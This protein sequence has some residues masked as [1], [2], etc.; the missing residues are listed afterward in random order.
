M[1]SLLHDLN[2][3]NYKPP[4]S[5]EKS[6]YIVKP[7]NG[8]QGRG[9]Y[10]FQS[11]N[12]YTR[13]N[14]GPTEVDGRHSHILSNTC[15]NASV[16]SF[17]A[18]LRNQNLNY[19]Q[20]ALDVVQR[21]EISPTLLFGY[22]TDLRV[23]AVIE[24]LVP[25]KIHIY[26][27]G[28]VRL[29]SR[30]YHT[31]DRSNLCQHT[32][33]LTNYAI[34]KL[35]HPLE[36]AAPV[37]RQTAGNAV[38]T[39]N[40]SQSVTACNSD[41]SKWHCKYSLSD[42][43]RPKAPWSH[44]DW[45]ALWSRV[46]DI[47]RHTIFTL[48]PELKVSYWAEYG[49]PLGI[50][51]TAKSH[52]LISENASTFKGP[53]CFQI[54][55]FDFLLVEPG[56]HPVLL[57]VN[58]NPSLRTDSVQHL[59]RRVSPQSPDA[60][61]EIV[62]L[63]RDLAAKCFTHGLVPFGPL[64]EVATVLSSVMGD[65]YAHFERS[66]VDEKVKGGLIRSTIQLIS[67][68]IVARYT[69]PLEP[70]ATSM[71]HTP[72]LY[73]DGYGIQ[74][75]ML[76]SSKSK[77]S[78]TPSS[79]TVKGLQHSAFSRSMLPTGVARSSGNPGS[80]VTNSICRMNRFSA[81]EKSAVE[82]EQG[83][84]ACSPSDQ[85]NLLETSNL[86]SQ[87]E[88]CTDTTESAPLDCIYFEGERTSH[89]TH[90]Y[91]DS[92]NMECQRLLSRL[93]ELKGSTGSL[94]KHTSFLDALNLDAFD[95]APR[96]FDLLADMFLS[97]LSS[98]KPRL[99]PMSPP[100]VNDQVTDDWTTATGLELGSI[101]PTKSRYIPRMDLTAFRTFCRRCRMNQLGFSS[102]E[103]DL[104]FAK[105]RNWWQRVY[106]TESAKQGR[107][108]CY[109]KGLSFPAFVELCVQLAEHCSLNEHRLWS[110]ANTIHLPEIPLSPRATPKKSTHSGGKVINGRCTS[111]SS[112]K[113][114]TA[115]PHNPVNPKS[116]KNTLSTPRQPVRVRL[117]ERRRH[118]LDQTSTSSNGVH[119]AVQYPGWDSS[120]ADPWTIESWKKLCH[121]IEH[122]C[123]DSVPN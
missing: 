106:E 90:S 58:S 108:L 17:T 85:P 57:E 71:L 7:D 54:L 118:R 116:P 20:P 72:G 60:E 12:P 111:S 100:K 114:C 80:L 33:H 34:N 26:R 35:Q 82:T 18:E 103:L 28:L 25:L 61:Y 101:P 39:N 120:D 62:E 23:Y 48:V 112:S 77:T 56:S 19:L 87:H 83:K 75:P 91:P 31:P 51:D 110:A 2:T 11:A 1:R 37:K 86:V 102:T 66:A 44:I 76:D 109:L 24:T 3:T 16:G 14:L 49:N 92:I 69:D 98:R 55:G 78:N 94:R 42:L 123:A 73:N 93:H 45:E 5:S 36:G 41:S 9:I 70:E 81:S 67:R 29:A 89:M 10:L 119:A 50:K 96:I 74:L 32:M 40:N 99:K 46:D 47:V 121:F 21:Y 53:N 63:N 65:R 113:A 95:S 105:H 104:I 84:L 38:E 68:N 6:T 97:V 30:T 122:C 88:K 22:K 13:Q 27:D 4:L 15:A 64:A 79:P 59:L 117:I 8:T 115:E 52:P 43:I 107:E